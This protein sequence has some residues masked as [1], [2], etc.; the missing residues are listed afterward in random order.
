MEQV[1]TCLEALTR[2]NA[3]Y[4]DIRFDVNPSSETGCLVV[5]AASDGIFPYMHCSPQ[6]SVESWSFSTWLI[7][8]RLALG[9]MGLVL[10]Q[11]FNRMMNWRTVAFLTLTSP[12]IIFTV[13]GRLHAH[14]KQDICANLAIQLLH[15]TRKGRER[16][17]T[18]QPC[19]DPATDIKHVK[20]LALAC[21]ST[22]KKTKTYVLKHCH[23][24][25]D[26]RWC[27]SRARLQKDQAENNWDPSAEL[28]TARQWPNMRAPNLETSDPS[29]EPQGMLRR[30]SARR[31]LAQG[32]AV[33]GVHV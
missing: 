29:F 25:S 19:S 13:D 26:L 11:G 33:D 12:C 16:G 7:A 2:H 27:R 6:V 5:Y 18:A 30:A 10:S 28:P 1:R 24:R 22:Q 9:A 15:P 17:Q 14:E 31:R 32:L 21:Q 4:L 20:V 8:L 3:Y 23:S